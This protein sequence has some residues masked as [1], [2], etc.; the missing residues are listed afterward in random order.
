MGGGR[1]RLRYE[2]ALHFLDARDRMKVGLAI[3]GLSH[4]LGGVERSERVAAFGLEVAAEAVAALGLVDEERL[5]A[6]RATAPDEVADRLVA[7]LDR[8]AAELDRR[9]GS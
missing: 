2:A 6:I 8:L 9:G 4:Q 1:V 5:A 7:E 3:Y